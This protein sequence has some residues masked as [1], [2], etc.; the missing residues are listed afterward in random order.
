M[1]GRDEAAAGEVSRALIAGLDEAAAAVEPGHCRDDVAIHEFRKAIK[2][3]RAL[4]RLTETAR[5]GAAAE[6]REAGALARRLSG[7][8]DLTASLEGLEDILDKQ[9][10]RAE[11]AAP[12]RAAL[13]T[14]RKAAEAAHLDDAVRAEVRAFLARARAEAAKIA[15][16]DIPV[17]SLILAIAKGYRR[18]VNAAPADWSAAPA[19]SLHELRKAV[20]IH[21]YQMELAQPLWPRPIELWIDEVQKLRDRLGQNQDL[22]ALIRF[23]AAAPHL[24]DARGRAR[25]LAAIRTRQGQHIAAAE[26][27]LAR[28]GAERPRAFAERLMAYAGQHTLTAARPHSATPAGRRRAAPRRAPAKT[29]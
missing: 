15:D 6:R 2:R 13:E 5:G 25:L 22:E 8:R 21:R 7:A 27:Q 23:V 10:I 9:L 14:T 28:L 26:E 3:H 11:L 16:A 24:C 29:P 19:E 1:L 4:L 12:V 17:R 18:M 20:V